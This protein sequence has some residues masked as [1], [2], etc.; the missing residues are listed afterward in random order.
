MNVHRLLT[1]AALCW[2][3]PAGWAAADALVITRAMRASTIA[4]IFIE[5]DAIRIELEIGEV[6]IESFRNLM[7]DEIYEELGNE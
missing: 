7:P 2:G 1:V 6:D 5:A 4:E 3:L